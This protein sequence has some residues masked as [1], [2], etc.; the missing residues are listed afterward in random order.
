MTST[1]R[2]RA[3]LLDRRALNRATLARQL[4]LDRAGMPAIEAIERLAGMQ[5]QAP[6]SPY[7]GLWTRLSG[8]GAGE[9][10]ELIDARQ[11]VR[12]PL[13]RA[14]LHLVSAADFRTIRPIVHPVLERGF[15]GAPFD[16]AG[17]ETGALLAAGRELIEQSPRTRTE[18]GAAAG[19]ALARE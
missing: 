19:R 13:M 11:A 9:L 15:A 3:E 17:I 7:V 8:F 12:G 18:L 16:I 4:L 10:S 1:R 2:T 5:A 6:H 14:T